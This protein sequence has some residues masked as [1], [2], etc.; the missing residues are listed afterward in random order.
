MKTSI[1]YFIFASFFSA[2]FFIA[3]SKPEVK[4]PGN[5]PSP[6]PDP[7]PPID[8]KS[9]PE[10]RSYVQ[11]AFTPGSSQI[12]IEKPQGAAKGDL[13]LLIMAKNGNPLSKPAHE[14]GWVRLVSQN[15]G[16]GVP[17][18]RAW[19]KEVTSEDPQ[20][21]VFNAG[22]PDN[23]GRVDLICIKNW[24]GSAPAAYSDATS[25]KLS[26][27]ETPAIP[28][29]SATGGDLL[30]NSVAVAAM[31]GLDNVKWSNAAGFTTITNQSSGALAMST[32]YKSESATQAPAN[33]EGNI[34]SASD[35][36]VARSAGVLSIVVPASSTRPVI[37]VYR[38]GASRTISGRDSSYITT[39]SL[40]HILANPKLGYDVRSIGEKEV[41]KISAA[42]LQNAAMY[43]QPGGPTIE[44]GWPYLADHKNVIRNYVDNG[45]KYLGTCFGAYMFRNYYAG[46]SFDLLP[47]GNY[48][49]TY[50]SYPGATYQDA[51]GTQITHLQ[52]YDIW[53]N[54]PRYVVISG[55]NYFK[56]SGGVPDYS[57]LATYIQPNGDKPPAAIRFSFNPS[58]D[59]T[60]GWVF[61]VGPHPEANAKT[62]GAPT[63]PDGLDWDLIE[64]AAADLLKR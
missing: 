62:W 43:V 41:S 48:A 24:N 42:N 23:S 55:G 25:A 39:E 63:D 16:S 21:Y 45:G 33:I 64:K 56:I 1:F 11:I 14:E 18:L 4:P 19:W 17:L 13:L 44:K 51:D 34:F 37:R 26:G 36:D 52:L 8:N 50:Q 3:C 29:I 9:V 2:M 12:A 32:V 35:I 27:F 7:K 54:D 57:V 59:N 60:K 20:S 22:S 28:A 53:G 47:P 6:P 10:V 30:L 49:Y 38:G 31:S 15:Y 40:I 5:E 61:G 46:K 58:G